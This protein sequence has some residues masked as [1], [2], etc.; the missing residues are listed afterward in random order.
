MRNLQERGALRRAE[1]QKWPNRLKPFFSDEPNISR[2]DLSSP[3][4]LALRC[5]ADKTRFISAEATYAGR[6]VPRHYDWLVLLRGDGH[7]CVP[8]IRFG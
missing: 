7:V 4:D 6:L 2:F 3:H 1:T 8:K 5:G